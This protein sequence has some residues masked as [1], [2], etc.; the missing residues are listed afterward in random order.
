MGNWTGKIKQHIAILVA[1]CV[2]AIWGET[3]VSTKMLLAE[4][5]MPSDIFIYRFV[6]GYACIWFLS[7]KRPWADTW[8]DELLLLIL[9][10]MG[11]SL[12]FLTENMAL[13]FSTAS[14]VAILVG[15]TPLI[16]AVLMSVFYKDERMGT[17]QTVGSLLAFTGMALVILNGQLMLHLNPKGDI[18]ALGASLTWACYSLLIKKLSRHY[19][20]LFITRKIFFYG[21]L[22]I[23][24]Y[25]WTECPL[26]TDIKILSKPTVW[27]NLLYL[28]VVASML[29]FVAWNWTLKRLGTVRATNIIYL[30]SFF[31]MFFSY[32][33][34]DEHITV[35]AV[36]GTV[37]LILGMYLASKT[38]I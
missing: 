34:L 13:M 21:I 3:F 14:N 32:L 25:L 6:L 8:Q 38:A 17:R 16:T 7:Y 1:L 9:G 10:I 24:P 27:V 22:T 4:G 11:G 30:Q 19:N 37:T 33:I 29:C 31:T 35:M 23:L 2:C 15:S 18:L 26:Q 20:S 36:C 5:L 28:G 12:Y